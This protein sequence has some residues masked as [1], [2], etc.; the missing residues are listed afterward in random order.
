MYYVGIDGGGTKTRVMVVDSNG[1]I[2]QDITTKGTNINRSGWDI[3]VN[4]L[5]SLLKSLKDNILGDSLAYVAVG[6]SG[7]DI[8]KERLLPLLQTALPSA[9][10]SIEHDT[11]PA[12]MSSLDEKI[13]IVMVSG[14][15]SIASGVDS[16]GKS[17]RAGGWGYL[18]GDEGSAYDIGLKALRSLMKS[19]DGRLENTIL[20]TSILDY[21]NLD[22]PKDIINFIYQGR[23][24][25]DAISEL[26]K[27][28]FLCAE[29]NDHVSVDILR[30]SA[31]E[32]SR[33]V[34]PLI[35]NLCFTGPQIPIVLAGGVT[36]NSRVF[37][38][39]LTDSIRKLTKDRTDVSIILSEFPPVIGAVKLAKLLEKEDIDRT[40]IDNLLASYSRRER[41]Y[42][43]E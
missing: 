1:S 12:L 9:K 37:T 16:F 8:H 11:M 26:S 42:E 4:I 32:L 5:L 25:Q 29:N 7:V 22:E 40:F 27:I 19:Y 17:L 13:G 30:E 38:T 28:V 35:N 6:L 21:L 23:S 3:A 31:C 18:L 36:K 43:S 20:T 39:F 33:L 14:T 41:C 2:I 24:G 10:F 15:G 34:N